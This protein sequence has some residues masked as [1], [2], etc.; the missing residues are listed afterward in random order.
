MFHRILVGFDGSDEAAHALRVALEL[1][2]A[3]HSEVI[4][5]SVVH[6]YGQV[7]SEDER[8]LEIA[9]ERQVAARGLDRY[10][11]HAEERGLTLGEAVVESSEPAKAL[12]SYVQEHGFD[13]LVVGR[14]GREHAWHL[15]KGHALDKV[16]QAVC[17]VLV[18]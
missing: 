10:K 4:A 17:P 12:V 18:V 5:L 14:H 15:G 9:A 11:E 1:A 13:L 6:S 16:L 2:E 3:V 8:K 7:E